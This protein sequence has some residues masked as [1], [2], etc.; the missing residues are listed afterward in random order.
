MIRLYAGVI[1]AWLADGEVNADPV[2]V[3]ATS[4][5]EAVG[6]MFLQAREQY[7]Q[8]DGWLFDVDVVAVESGAVDAAHKAMEAEEK[9]Q[10]DIVLDDL[11]RAFS[12][13]V[14]KMF[15]IDY[16]YGALGYTFPRLKF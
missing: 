15:H 1:L 16:P 13:P 9:A 3:L 8:E 5:E 12:A 7:T 4:E 11:K 2:S 14:E 10:R 6:K